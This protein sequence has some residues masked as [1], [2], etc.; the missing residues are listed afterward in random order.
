M[1]THLGASNGRPQSRSC[2]A[3]R[4][5]R[6]LRGEPCVFTRTGRERHRGAAGPARRQYSFV[7]LETAGDRLDRRIR[8][9]EIPIPTLVRSLAWRRKALDERASA[10]R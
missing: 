1:D 10:S 2:G 8:A 9:L 4:C 6:L 7:I 3:R 5:V